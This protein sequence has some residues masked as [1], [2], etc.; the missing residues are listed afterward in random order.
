[1]SEGASRSY[2]ILYLTLISILLLGIAAIAY[3]WTLKRD[4]LYNK[5]KENLALQ[6]DQELLNEMLSDYTGGVSKDLKTDFKNM[7]ETYDKLIA[8]DRSKADSLNLQKERISEL[9][10]QLNANRN[11]SAKQLMALKKENDVLR[12]IMRG[13]V[14]QIDS[15]NT[16]NIQLGS[17]LDET[18]NKLNSTS[19][20]RDNY[21]RDAEEKTER[22]K[23]GAKLQAL[24]FTSI[25]LMSQFGKMKEADKA[26][27]VVQ[28][29]S[30]FTI[31]ENTLASAGK[32]SVYMQVVAPDGK[33]LTNRS[34]TTMET[35]QGT[36]TYSDKK[37]IDYQNEAIDLTIYYD[38]RGAELTKGSYKILI[39]CDGQ[40]IGKDSFVLR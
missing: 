3:M 9:L 4:E 22:I 38:I 13:Y 32:K 31:G 25:G 8:M 18:K 6:K 36:L 30:T 5:E 14:M 2:K 26:K 16:L 24:G 17:T 39:Y 12:S 23:K 21:K 11:L 27:K 19:E 1:M 33:V 34:N 37:D 10:N 15:L 40:L 29:K 20:E 28:I 35:D 7:L